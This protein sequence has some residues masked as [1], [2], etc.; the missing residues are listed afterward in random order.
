MLFLHII[1]MLDMTASYES[2][3]DLMTRFISLSLCTLTCNLL[4]LN[5]FQV[6]FLLMTLEIGWSA[7]VIWTAGDTMC[8][9]M[10]FF[11]TFGLY[12]SSFVLVCISIDR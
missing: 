2:L 6:T 5:H 7:T 4:F 9:I 3:S 8:R 1:S 12:L 10:A 11:R